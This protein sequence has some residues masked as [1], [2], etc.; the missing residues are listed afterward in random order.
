MNRRNQP[1][2]LLYRPRVCYLIPRKPQGDASVPEW[3]RSSAWFEVCG[4][5]NL[6]DRARFDALDA[7]EIEAGLGALGI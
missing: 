4:G 2:N 5:F 6:A 7:G 1:F 3:L